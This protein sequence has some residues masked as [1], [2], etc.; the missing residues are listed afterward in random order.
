MLSQ[1]AFYALQL[2]SYYNRRLWTSP[3]FNMEFE[4]QALEKTALLLKRVI[5]SFP[6]ILK[7][8]MLPSWWKK[9]N[10]LGFESHT[11]HGRCL[12]QALF[13]SNMEKCAALCMTENTLFLASEWQNTFTTDIV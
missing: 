10:S 9:P 13:L 1:I 3:S 2:E 5:S 8:F 6:F 11:E 7:L 12:S 4:T